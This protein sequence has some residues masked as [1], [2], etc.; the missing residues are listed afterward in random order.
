MM[1]SESS[2]QHLLCVPDAVQASDT[3]DTKLNCFTQGWLFLAHRR[4]QRSAGVAALGSPGTW[5]PA[6]SSPPPLVQSC[7][8]QGNHTTQDGSL[9]PG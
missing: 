4:A 6:T 9:A 7:L 2:D 5:A 8:L 1:P 3:R